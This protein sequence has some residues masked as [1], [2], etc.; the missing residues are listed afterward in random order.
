VRRFQL[1]D[2]HKSAGRKLREVA[3]FEGN[4]REKKGA[5]GTS[6]QQRKRVRA[7]RLGQ[8]RRSSRMRMPR[9]QYGRH[10]HEMT[11]MGASPFIAMAEMAI[12]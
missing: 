10:H 3:K 12:Q 9:D 4:Q 6:I 8:Q 2:G 5:R 11:V 1:D 7:T